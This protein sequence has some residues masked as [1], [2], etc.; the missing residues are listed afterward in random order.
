MSSISSQEALPWCEGCRLGDWSVKYLSCA[1]WQCAQ[2]S[3]YYWYMYMYVSV[4]QKIHDIVLL[5]YMQAYR[6]LSTHADHEGWPMP[7]LKFVKGRPC[8]YWLVMGIV[9]D[10][11]QDSSAEC[12]HA[13]AD[14]GLPMPAIG[15]LLLRLTQKV[16]TLVSLERLYAHEVRAIPEGGRT[17]SAVKT[18]EPRCE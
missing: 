16:L 12:S 10:F 15:E 5:P 8:A 7:L 2:V 1:V 18:Q 6:Q 13:P 4:W 14:L 17:R 9:S 11:S 3:H